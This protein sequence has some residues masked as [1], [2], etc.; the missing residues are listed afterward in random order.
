MQP[1]MLTVEDACADWLRSRHKIRPTTAAGY[2]YVLQ[3]VRSELGELAVQDVTRRHID[4][5][6]MQLRDG[7]LARPGGVRAKRGAHDLATTCSAHSP[8]SWANL[9]PRDG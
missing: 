3:P 8:K 6:I 9:L 1:S 2:E 5:L 7:T 4:G